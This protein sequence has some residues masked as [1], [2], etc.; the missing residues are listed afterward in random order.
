MFSSK[1]PRDLS[2]DPEPYRARDWIDAEGEHY[3][4][5]TKDRAWRVHDARYDPRPEFDHAQHNPPNPA[6]IAFRDLAKGHGMDAAETRNLAR[7]WLARAHYY[8]HQMN[9]SARDLTKAGREHARKVLTRLAR[10]GEM[11]KA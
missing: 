2:H 3:Y 4:R 10:L 9:I 7:Q 1:T 11:E 6:L 8:E 5:M